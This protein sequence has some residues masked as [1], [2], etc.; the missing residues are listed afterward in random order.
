MQT[1]STL[2]GQL[3]LGESEKRKKD[4]KIVQFIFSVK[5]KFQYRQ[6]FS[7][8]SSKISAIFVQNIRA[9]VSGERVTYVDFRRDSER[10]LRRTAITKDFNPIIFQP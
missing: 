2:N 8:L 6:K 5:C 10:L 4:M 1:G 3:W 7:S 9:T